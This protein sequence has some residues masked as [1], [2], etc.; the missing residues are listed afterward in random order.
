[1]D[2]LVEIIGG[3][4]IMIL[5]WLG[6]QVRGMGSRL[7]ALEE[8]KLDKI[9]Y[10]DLNQKIEKMTETLVELKVELAKW[11]GRSEAEDNNRQDRY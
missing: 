11:R 6:F 8:K 4:I 7:D 5:G 3:L 1:M 10:N 2:A 9:V